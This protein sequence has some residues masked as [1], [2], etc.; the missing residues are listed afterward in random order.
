VRW[1]GNDSSQPGQP[2]DL[3]IK[4][5]RENGAEQHKALEAPSSFKAGSWIYEIFKPDSELHLGY[6]WPASW[7][8]ARGR[9]FAGFPPLDPQTEAGSL[10]RRWDG[11]CVLHR[12]GTA[13]SFSPAAGESPARTAPGAA[14]A[15]DRSANFRLTVR[16]I[17]LELGLDLQDKVF[18]PGDSWQVP[19]RQAI[20]QPGDSLLVAAPPSGIVH[21]YVTL[22]NVSP[23]GDVTSVLPTFSALSELTAADIR[24]DGSGCRSSLFNASHD[25]A[26]KALDRLWQLGAE[27]AAYAKPADSSIYQGKTVATV[28]HALDLLSDVRARQIVYDGRTG[29]PD[30]QTAVDELFARPNGDSN[31]FT[32]GTGGEFPSLMTALQTLLAG[33]RR[34]VRLF[35]LPGDHVLNPTAPIVSPAQP[36]HLSLAGSG[37]ATRLLVRQRAAFNNFASLTFQSL[38][39]EIDPEMTIEVTNGELNLLDNRISG[40]SKE[41]LLRPVG[42]TRLLVRDNIVEVSVGDRA[43]GPGVFLQIGFPNIPTRLES[44]QI[45][46]TVALYGAPGAELSEADLST[47]AGRI[48]GGLGFDISATADLVASGNRM[49]GFQAGSAMIDTLLTRTPVFPLFQRLALSDNTFDSPLNQ[50]VANSVE[51]TGNLLTAAPFG[52]VVGEEALFVGNAVRTDVTVVTAVRNLVQA[53]N[54]A[55]LRIRP[56]PPVVPK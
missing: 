56:A 55:R 10:V 26:Q 23:A 45:F 44:N 18:L 54:S 21:R 46:G 35:L 13:W 6:H 14:V 37:W 8:P 20:H 7:Q 30:V 4:W 2:T 41:G 48:A 15:L 43:A 16:L 11:F 40:F 5:S 33:S 22:A 49:S 50:L 47:V 51:L 27:H 3:V 36:V 1:A 19:V 9:L 28:R 32:V 31:G 25:T 38:A 24:Y 53:G 34:D 12:S 29:V 17:D 42:C 52:W 39:I